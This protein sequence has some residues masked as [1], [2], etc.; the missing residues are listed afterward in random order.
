VGP[1]A[2]A[3]AARSVGRSPPTTLTAARRARTAR[4]ARSLPRRAWAR[5][6]GRP[7]AA[8]PQ[9]PRARA[10]R[11]ARAGGPGPERA[12]TARARARAQPLAARVAPESPE[13]AEWRLPAESR[14]AA[15]AMAA[16]AQAPW[17]QAA[18]MAARG[19]PAERP[20]LGALP[21]ARAEKRSSSAAESR[22]GR[23]ESLTRPEATR[24]SAEP[25][26]VARLAPT[27]A[28][29]MRRCPA[30]PPR[31]ARSTPRLDGRGSGG[32]N[33]AMRGQENA[34][35]PWN[36]G[37]LCHCP[38]RRPKQARGRADV[39][40]RTAGLTGLVRD[41]LRSVLDLSPQR[42]GSARAGFSSNWRGKGLGHVFPPP[43]AIVQTWYRACSS[44]LRRPSRSAREEDKRES[45][46][47]RSSVG[48]AHRQQPS[49]WACCSDPRHRSAPQNGGVLNACVR[50]D[51]R[52]NLHGRLRI[53][54]PRQRCFPGEVLV[55]LPLAGAGGIAGPP[56]PQGPQGKQGPAGPQGPRGLT[57]L[58]D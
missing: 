6:A 55:T 47:R 39:R 22:A 31:G 28:T 43:H 21:G 19:R 30:R 52:G 54:E 23:A 8:P 45:Y 49:W 29:S 58:T 4:S 35:Q 57:G 24:R 26:T 50:V 2:R 34:G 48:L 33:A 41:D 13:A 27:R 25:V 51:R 20:A 46:A 5:A 32:G 38:A 15:A 11:W 37:P 53:V 16:R 3:S 1:G 36:L 40:A 18:A 17:P 10:V 12:R 56:G 44:P 42:D 7:E 9:A 14:P